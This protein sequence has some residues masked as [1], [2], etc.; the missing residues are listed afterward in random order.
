MAIALDVV[1]IEVVRNALKSISEE[2]GKVLIRS[3]YSTNIKEREDC[4]TAI[5]DKKGRTIAIAEY[6]PLHFGSMLG[7]VEHIV[8][9]YPFDEIKDG[10][11]FIANDPYSGGGTHLPDI[12]IASPFFYNGKLQ[13]FVAS[14]GH[15]S[16]RRRTGPTIYEEG[17]RIPVL[18]IVKENTF[19]E[20]LLE[21]ILLNYQIREERIG[22][23]RAQLAAN[24]R[25]KDRLHQIFK[26]YGDHTIT[27]SMKEILLYSKKRGRAA[28]QSI[29]KGTC[30]F[31]DYMDD[32]GR[33]NK[34]LPIKVKITIDTD[35][36]T[37]DFSG[38]A[39][40]VEG[41][42]NLVEASLRAMVY[43]AIKSTLDP[44]LPANTGFF[45]TIDVLA[46]K[47]TIVNAVSPAPV[48][49]RS[50]TAQRVADAIFGALAEIIPEKVTAAT[51][52]ANTGI[53]FM[54]INHETNAPYSYLE[55][56]GGGGGARYNKDGLDGI[57]VHCSNTSNLPVEA[58]EI[59]YPL[60][61]EEYAL[62]PDSCGAGRYR[63]GL[64]IRRDVRI[65]KHKCTIKTHGERH[66]IAPWGLFRGRKGKRATFRI[67]KKNG[68]AYKLRSKAE[69]TLEDGDIIS[70]ITAGGGGYG[71]PSHRPKEMLELDLINGKT[72]PKI[73]KK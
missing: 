26:K 16:D 15:H 40:Q 58:M 29:P 54:G 7:L 69:A 48:E 9:R 34:K 61:I 71:P 12:T 49:Y 36:I 64:G 6:Q 1:T 46:P 21:F 51:H 23:I 38:T 68:K 19:Q 18:K 31:V 33:G 4:S 72:S 56:I 8:T 2:M 10:D 42:I 53:H 27:K 11:A 63:G 5:F 73:A 60:R 32:D 14:V 28:I 3:S 35:T 43:Y 41:N 37:V 30:E 39:Q 47:G 45:E 22:D 55:T 24:R 44:H 62:V 20:D 65:L 50:E 13:A 57:Q 59:E 70:V 17:L 67:I 52:G 25:G 66:T